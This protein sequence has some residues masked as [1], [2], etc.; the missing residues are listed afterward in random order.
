MRTKLWRSTR[1]RPQL[2]TN[3]TT[4]DVGDKDCFFIFAI[5]RICH[6][7]EVNFNIRCIRRDCFIICALMFICYSYAFNC[8]I[9]DNKNIEVVT[10]KLL[11]PQG[12]FA[13]NTN[14]LNKGKR[15]IKKCHRR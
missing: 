6:H 3:R 2:S 5:Y 1:T 15:L 7:D 13:T 14:T 8:Y 4:K 10:I 11:L 12:C 9:V